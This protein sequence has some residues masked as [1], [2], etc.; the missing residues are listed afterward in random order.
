MGKKLSGKTNQNDC[1]SSGIRNIFDNCPLVPNRKQTNSDWDNV[2]DACDNCP[3]TD[4]ADQ[5]GDK[6]HA[7][8]VCTIFRGM[9]GD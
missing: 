7:P 3:V 6:Y 5:V 1:F 9:L 8:N 4:N 2:G